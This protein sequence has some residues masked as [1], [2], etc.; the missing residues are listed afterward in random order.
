LYSIYTPT[1]VKEVGVSIDISP[2]A[3]VFPY[4][5]IE[6]FKRVSNKLLKDWIF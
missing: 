1:Q 3:A 4:I 5:K 2:K 6:A